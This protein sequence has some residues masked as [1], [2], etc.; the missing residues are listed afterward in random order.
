[1]SDRERNLLFILVTMAFVAVNFLG[2]K[3][4]YQPKMTA[5]QGAQ[6][7]AESKASTNETMGNALSARQ[8]DLDWIGRYEPK[9]TTLGKMRTKIQQLAENEANRA[10]LEIFGRGRFGDAVEGPTLSYHLARYELEVRGSEASIY[11]WLD[12]L[13]SPNDFRAISY[14]K[15]TPVRDDL[16]R[17]T[18]KIYLDQW[19]V[20]EGEQS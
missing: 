19:F 14:L 16:A 1:M 17:A 15:I 9:P 13:H 18:C 8:P 6:A 11:R 4:W 3:L 5:L 2:Y 20:P 7:S 10:Q 12:R